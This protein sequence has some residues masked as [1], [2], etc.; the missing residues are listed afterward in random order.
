MEKPS[1]FLRVLDLRQG[2]DVRGILII[3]LVAVL[4]W[5]FVG[6]IGDWALPYRLRTV[7]AQH[8]VVEERWTGQ[9]LV[10][11]DEAVAHTPATGRLTLY[12]QEGQQVRVGD[13]IC[14]INA[15]GETG[16]LSVSLEQL[17][18]QMAEADEAIRVAR[19][20]GAQQRTQLTEQLETLRSKISVL[21][22]ESKFE[23]IAKLETEQRTLEMRL[24]MVAGTEARAVLEAELRRQELLRQREKLLGRDQSEVFILRAVNPGVISFQFDGLEELIPLD[25]PLHDVA[26]IKQIAGG[27]AFQSGGSRITAGSPVYRLINSRQFYLFV[28]LTNSGTL[29]VGETVRVQLADIVLPMTLI[30]MEERVDK[31]LALLISESMLPELLNIRYTSVKVSRGTHQGVVLPLASI[32]SP[33]ENQTGVYL[34]VDGRPVY[35]SVKVRGQDGKQ[36]VVDGVP[37]GAKVVIN[38]KLLTVD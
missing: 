18:E 31:L 24:R 22:A 2:P 5:F 27:K 29:S 38:P 8:G 23:E 28:S 32:V 13:I 3:S 20:E 36:A 14:E 35:R 9:G 16:A 19:R 26:A 10:V 30:R 37:L 33:K 15:A 6:R 12:V 1:S 34:M 11:R 17:D 21:Q 25:T 4:I 7:E